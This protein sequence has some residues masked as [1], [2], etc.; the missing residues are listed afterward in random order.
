MTELAEVN[1]TNNRGRFI[2]LTRVFQKHLSLLIV[3]VL[4]IIALAIANAVI[5]YFSKLQID[6]LESRGAGVFSFN[7]SP[8]P[9][10][11]ILLLVP[12]LIELVRLAVFHRLEYRF[13][14]LL[15]VKVQETTQRLVWKKMGEL[16]AGFFQSERN[17]RL[18]YDVTSSSYVIQEFFRFI[19]QRLSSTF[20]LIA[21]IPL[22]GLVSWQLLVLVMVTAILQY[23]VNLKM[24]SLT[25][26]YSFL[27]RRANEKAWK[28]QDLLNESFFQLQTMGAVERFISEYYVLLRKNE[29]L[30]FERERRSTLFRGY[31]WFLENLLVIAT[32]IFVG[33]QVIYGDLSVGTFT[34][35]VSY[36]TQISS[37]FR[38]LI[39]SANEWRSITVSLTKLH[40]FFHL[41]SRLRSVASPDSVPSRPQLLEMK[42]VSFAY[43]PHS[44]EERAYLKYMLKEKKISIAKSRSDYDRDQVEELEKILNEKPSVKKVL[45][46]ASLQ[47]SKGKIVALVGRNGS[48][49]TTAT[50]VLQH[51][52]E[53]SA[54][55]ALLDGKPLYQYRPEELN[56]TFGWLHQRPFILERYTVRDNLLLGARGKKADLE[57]RMQEAIKQLHLNELLKNLPKGLESVIGEDTSFSGGQE[58]LLAIARV[59]IQQR[60]FVI[61]DEGSSQLDV[62]KEFAVLQLLKDLR[63]SAGILFITHRMSVAKKADYIYVMNKGEIVEEGTHAELVDKKGLYS[64]FWEMQIVS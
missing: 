52:Y 22:L 14:S 18:L 50:H 19:T 20:T 47:L 4:V 29:D 11:G 32:N 41:K 48:G 64:R 28:L 42:K 15:N 16:D 23:L 53:P 1:L 17:K 26:G 61:F 9:F 43:P 5:P 24:T 25:E 51:H 54:G 12:A 33:Y 36:T 44:E 6:L 39:S 38:T 31:S 45:K 3:Y 2:F 35:V 8:V 49:K 56:E 46:N 34:L 30:Y 57:Q 27:E 10:L 58:Q 21:I 37:F 59:L 40:F 63:Q 55:E 62:E 7:L 13:W 60:P